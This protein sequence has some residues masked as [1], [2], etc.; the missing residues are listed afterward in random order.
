MSGIDQQFAKKHKSKVIKLP[1]TPNVTE[2]EIQDELDIW[3]A[4]GFVLVDIGVFANN[5]W[6]FFIKVDE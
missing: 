1:S 3:L 4:K 5:V 2:Q 6:A